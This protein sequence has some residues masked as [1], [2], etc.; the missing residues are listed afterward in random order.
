MAQELRQELR[1]A[2][3][4]IVGHEELQ[5]QRRREPGHLALEEPHHVVTVAG[6]PREDERARAGVGEDILVLS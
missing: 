6:A 1:V 5:G 4:R 3:H 2:S